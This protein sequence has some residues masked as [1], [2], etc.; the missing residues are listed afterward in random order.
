[1]VQLSHPYMT[2]GKNVALT[3]RTF[4]GKIMSLLFNIL[5]RFGMA[6]FPSSK[7]LLISWLQSPSIVILEPKKIKSVPIRCKSKIQ[8]SHAP[9]PA[10]SGLLHYFRSSQSQG[11]LTSNTFTMI[12]KCYL[13]YFLLSFPRKRPVAFPRG[14]MF[15]DGIIALIADDICA[16]VILYFNFHF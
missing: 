14:Y 9:G 16:C 1:M 3:I 5:S 15:C 6:F 12:M 7:H 13:S 2:D 10:L 8:A 4:V 11:S